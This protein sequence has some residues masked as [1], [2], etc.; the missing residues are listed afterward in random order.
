M[1]I[2]VAGMICAS[3]CGD[4]TNNVVVVTNGDAD[5]AVPTGVDAT[6]NDQ[7]APPTEGGT[8]D[9]A[10][11]AA[12]ID[13][14][15]G[16]ANANGTDA[17]DA[18]ADADADATT[19]DPVFGTTSF[20]PGNP[21]VNANDVAEHPA[22]EKPLE[23]K[24]C[25]KAGGCHSENNKKW[26]FAGTVYSTINGGVTVKGAEVRVSDSAGNVVGSVYTD[27]DGNFWFDGAKPPANARVGVRNATSKAIM[28]AVVAGDPG[29]QCNSGAC[30]G[31]AA[32]RV[33]VP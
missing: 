11:D 6:V 5:A 32:M 10:A 31:M 24:N 8:T 29:A 4:V 25:F 3:A 15:S 26:G 20:A 2:S 18:S 23:G 28:A 9:V 14:D 27:D 33:Y 19:S 21:G 30:H 7:G 12:V 1:V 22:A 16:D 17:S 13:G